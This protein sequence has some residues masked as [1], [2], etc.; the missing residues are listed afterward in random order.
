MECQRKNQRLLCQGEEARR[1]TQSYGSRHKT[2]DQVVVTVRA[3]NPSEPV[4][5]G[6]DLAVVTASVVV[7]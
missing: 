1:V 6:L 7:A 3:T 4:N 5:W 2:D